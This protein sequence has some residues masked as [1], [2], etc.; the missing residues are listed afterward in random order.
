MFSWF[1]N[2]YD[3]SPNRIFFS[4]FSSRA[5]IFHVIILQDALKCKADNDTRSYSDLL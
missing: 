1:Y 3:M 5:W 4:S 2:T